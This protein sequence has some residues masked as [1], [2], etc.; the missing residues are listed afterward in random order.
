MRHM[1]KLKRGRR[2]TMTRAPTRWQGAQTPA[3][4][5]NVEGR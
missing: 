1:L 3:D 5:P 2:M 4:T